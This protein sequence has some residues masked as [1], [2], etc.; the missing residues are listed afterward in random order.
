MEWRGL[1]G[2]VVAPP[3]R[4]ASG[5]VSAWVRD[6]DAPLPAAPDAILERLVPGGPAWPESPPAGPVPPA[7]YA[8]AA[9][10]LAPQPVQTRIPVPVRE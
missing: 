9:A 7:R 8:A 10:A 6:L 3:S 1:G 5:A 4:H 2:W